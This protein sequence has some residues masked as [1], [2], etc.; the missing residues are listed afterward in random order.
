M[1]IMIIAMV[2]FFLTISFGSSPRREVYIYRS[3]IECRYADEGQQDLRKR[4]SSVRD[5]EEEDTRKKGGMENSSRDHVHGRVVLR[6]V[7]GP[8]MLI[9]L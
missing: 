4:K 1:M 3:K 6:D 5:E 8:A 7:A 2:M 9:S